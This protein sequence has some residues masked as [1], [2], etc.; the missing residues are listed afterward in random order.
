MKKASRSICVGLALTSVLGAAVYATDY[1]GIDASN[2]SFDEGTDYLQTMVDGCAD[3]SAE[4]LYRA[5][6]SEIQRNIKIEQLGLDYDQTSFFQLLDEDGEIMDA[7][8][9]FAETGNIYGNTQ[10]AVEASA[11]NCREAANIESNKI[12]ALTKGS[13]VTFLTRTTNES[14]EVWYEVTCGNN[15]GWCR[16]D[17]LAMYDGSAAQATAAASEAVQSTSETSSAP[18]SDYSQDDLFYLAA[19]ITKEAGSNWITDEHQM[20]VGNVILN[21][22]A[23]GSYPNSVYGV[24]TQAGQYPWASGASSVVPSARAYANAQRLLNGERILPANVVYQSTVTQG[25]GVYTS[26]YDATLG[27]TT[28][29]CY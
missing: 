7:V 23:S 15:T 11:L 28:Y 29:F 27:T 1:S 20:M 22:V 3:G 9:V 24:I 6:E 8:M 18:A 12:C 2:L 17:F 5:A 16:A 4:A 14:G 26:V 19:A 13:V 10:Y 21:R 25:S